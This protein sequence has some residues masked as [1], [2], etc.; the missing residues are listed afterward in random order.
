MSAAAGCSTAGS[1]SGLHPRTN[2]EGL[3]QIYRGD[4]NNAAEI[5]GPGWARSGEYPLVD[6]LLSR[7]HP[8]GSGIDTNKNKV[9]MGGNRLGVRQSSLGLHRTSQQPWR[10]SAQKTYIA[11]AVCWSNVPPS[12][13]GSLQRNHQSGWHR[14][15]VVVYHLVSTTSNCHEYI[16]K[17]RSSSQNAA[18]IPKY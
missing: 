4:T 13:T 5:S 6:C 3:E 17:K 1:P 15:L 11:L 18:I 16:L 2:R 12:A 9:S 7:A 10:P 14:G 8:S